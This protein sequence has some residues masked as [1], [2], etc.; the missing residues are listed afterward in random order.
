ME[1]VDSRNKLHSRLR[2]WE[3]PDQY[4]IEPADGSGSSC[5]DISRVDASMKLI[6]WFFL[7][8]TFCLIPFTGKCLLSQSSSLAYTV[9]RSSPRKQFRACP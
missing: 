7:F 3:F 9:L 4:I 6:G 5:L 1:T 8:T 2:L